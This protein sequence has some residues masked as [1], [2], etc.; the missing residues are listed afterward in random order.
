MNK[1]ITNDQMIK[2][3]TCLTCSICNKLLYLP[4]TLHCQ[5]TFCCTCLK[6]Y[7]MKN[8]SNCSNCPK[9]KKNIFVPPVHNYKIW[10]LIT[11]L[12]SDEVLIREKETSNLMPKLTEQELIKEELIKNHWRD[13]VNKKQTDGIDQIIL[14]QLF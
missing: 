6:I 2:L 12:F 3:K 13:V 5:D 1:E 4:I 8:N 7:N 10:E 14:Q 11:K 9:C